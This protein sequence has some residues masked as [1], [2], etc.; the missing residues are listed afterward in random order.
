MGR[1]GS[2][3]WEQQHPAQVMR[4]KEAG[5]MGG[6]NQ[7]APVALGLL[8]SSMSSMPWRAQSYHDAPRPPPYPATF[9]PKT[10]G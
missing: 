9:P 3:W 4:D 7:D 10:W 5:D 2:P 6:M 1:D 8:D